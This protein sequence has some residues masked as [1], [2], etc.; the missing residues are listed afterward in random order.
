LPLGHRGNGSYGHG[1]NPGM[2]AGRPPGAML[3][4]PPDLAMLMGLGLALYPPHPP[5]HMLQGMPHGMHPMSQMGAPL[6]PSS[7][8]FEPGGAADWSAWGHH[9]HHH[10]Q[11]HI[12]HQHLH[13]HQHHHQHYPHHN[14]NNYAAGGWGSVP[15]GAPPEVGPVP[16]VPP[17][18]PYLR[19]APS[20]RKL[21]TVYVR[22]IHL[23]V[24]ECQLA[25]AFES[26]GAGAVVDC[27]LCSDP[28]S[29]TRFAF[30]AFGTPSAAAAAL[31]LSGASVG[32]HPVRVMP[33]KTSVIPVN[34]MLLPQT[35]SEL[36][37]CT[38]TVYVANVD[39]GVR[40]EEVRGFFTVACGGV[41][42][43]HLQVNARNNTKF[44]F[45]E[46]EVAES[47]VAALACS[48]QGPE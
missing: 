46:F 11:N 19:P 33:S 45:V 40:E 5:P 27:R 13:H 20:K 18:E 8:S 35:E 34:P 43:M 21:H 4:M 29:A 28:Y 31:L 30:A 7:P 1:V 6:P 44:A 2:A 25:Q 23:D 38:R 36:E 9:H 24:T 3:P 16:P 37:C 42:R 47:A 17:Q 26:A 14:N 12:F 48:G 39:H 15:P 32:G 22:D 41:A 10:Q